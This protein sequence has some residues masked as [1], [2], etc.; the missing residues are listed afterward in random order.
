MLFGCLPVQNIPVFLVMYGV[1]AFCL[2]MIW[3]DHK[4]FCLRMIW[5]DHKDEQHA[6]GVARVRR[7]EVRRRAMFLVEQG[8][9]SRAERMKAYHS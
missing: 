8:R 3:E 7:C 4:D 6:R 2:R 1:L 9:K 5:E